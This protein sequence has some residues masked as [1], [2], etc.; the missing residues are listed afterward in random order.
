MGF[1]KHYK[2]SQLLLKFSCSLKLSLVKQGCPSIAFSLKA[3]HCTRE[4]VKR[5]VHLL[6][7]L[8]LVDKVLD[9]VRY[10]LPL[11][12]IVITSKFYFMGHVI[13]QLVEYENILVY[14]WLLL[15]YS[16]VIKV[17]INFRHYL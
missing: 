6:S 1:F 9:L 14:L 7:R 13:G 3:S 17:P 5:R 2:F 12:L 4:D 16:E 10:T 8:V 11:N 15:G